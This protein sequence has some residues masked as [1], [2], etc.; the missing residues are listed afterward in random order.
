MSPTD[1]R[2][3]ASRDRLYRGAARD[4]PGDPAPG[5]NASIVRHILYLEGA[6]R[7]S[8]YLSF[9][10][11]EVVAERFAGKDGRVWT[12]SAPVLKRHKVGHIS[13]R[14]LT[15]WLRGTGKGRAEWSSVWEVLRARQYVEENAEHLA[16]FSG[17]RS[18]TAD[19]IRA[20][21][22]KVLE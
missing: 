4:A 2:W 19:E 8:P 20:L 18:M 9:S 12:S 16:D 1:R 11:D 10:E 3:K 7:E 6:G 13:R 21:L 15:Q 17:L 22:A 14:E 5:A